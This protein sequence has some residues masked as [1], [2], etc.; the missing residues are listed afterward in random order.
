MTKLVIFDL[1]GTLLNTIADLANSTNY[2]L[3]QC[4]FP[5][6]KTNEYNFFVGNGINKLFERALPEGEKTEEN[7]LRVRKY[8]LAHY[9]KNCNN[10]S[11]PYPGIPEL[12]NTLHK[13]GIMLAVASNKYQQATLE[14]I[15]YYFPEVP[16][17][18][19]LGLRNGIPAKP[20]PTIVY[21]TLAI[22]GVK[23][24]EALYVGDSGV[25]METV[26]NSGV[27]G[28]AVTW[29]FRPRQELEKFNPGHIVN[30]AGDILSLL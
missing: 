27:R 9:D 18:S 20:D 14:L 28:V 11:R 7:I 5:I 30:N 16:F 1:D 10:Y 25:D 13:K 21:E 6:H 15:N 29:G 22:A 19:I 12:L 26:N 8:F 2:A 23:K 17:V 4:G 3:T 24:E